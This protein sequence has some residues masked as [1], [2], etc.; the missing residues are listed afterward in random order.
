M[1]DE[2]TEI[3]PCAVRGPSISGDSLSTSIYRYPSARSTLETILPQARAARS[4]SGC[5]NGYCCTSAYVFTVILKSSQIRTA[6]LGLA[7]EITGVAPNCCLHLLNDS[8]LEK[9]V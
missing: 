1:E 5:G 4:F 2:Y 6:S 9:T 7:T 3:A 8:E